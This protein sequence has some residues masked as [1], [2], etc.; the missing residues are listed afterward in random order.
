M[1]DTISRLR[2]VLEHN[3]SRP[4]KARLLAE[5]L[6]EGR[7]YRWVGLYD[8]GPAEITAIAWTGSESPAFPSFPITQGLNGAAAASGKPVVVQDV[9]QDPRWLTTFGSTRAETIFPVMGVGGTVVGTI[10]VESDR[11]GAFCPDDEAL[12]AEAARVLRPFW[13][14]QTTEGSA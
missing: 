4:A 1:I 5:T 6:R 7:N 2:A 12:L 13:T 3:L 9:S 10:D 14:H 11:I 8:V